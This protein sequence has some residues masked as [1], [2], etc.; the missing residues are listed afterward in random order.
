[1]GIMYVTLFNMKTERML[2]RATAEF[3]VHTVR[4]F[5]RPWLFGDSRK[6]GTRQKSR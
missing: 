2:F 1:M 5:S 4:W 6:Y 3:L